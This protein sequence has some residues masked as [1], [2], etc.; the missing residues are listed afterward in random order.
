MRREPQEDTGAAPGLIATLTAGFE[1]T[2][3]HLWLIILPVVLDLFFWIGPRLSVME[4]VEKAASALSVEPAS[5]E[6]VDQMLGLAPQ[7]NLFTSLSLPLIGI[8][9][10]MSGAVPESTPVSPAVIQIQSPGIW[11]L[12]FLSLTGFGLLLTTIYL[13]LIGKTIR[14]ERGAGMGIG[15]FARHVAVSAGRLLG[16]VF[17]SLALLFLVM[18]PLLPLALLLGLVGIGALSL[19]VI[20]AGFALVVI[21]LSMAVPGILL[22]GRPVRSAIAESIRLVHTNILQTLGLL[23]LILIIGNGMNQLWHLAD[24]GSWLTVVSIAGHGFVSTAL[25]VALFVFYRDR[26]LRLGRASNMRPPTLPRQ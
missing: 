20:F 10:L 17:I 9:A 21:Y 13:N 15:P 3:K 7:I 2:T 24:D 16:L 8:P 12:L 5:A 23:V 11:L 22:N 25:A 19:A 26:F 14:E 1:L 18:L 6:L 4:V